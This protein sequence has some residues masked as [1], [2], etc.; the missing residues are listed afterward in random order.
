MSYDILKAASQ[1]QPKK[2]D[3]TNSGKSVG[4]PS[5]ELDAKGKP[6]TYE[7]KSGPKDTRK[8]D[9]KGYMKYSARIDNGTCLF[10]KYF[11][12]LWD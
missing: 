10:G 4:V 7:M 6:L 9:K 1:Q 8:W 5:K 12:A 11:R 2:K 3:K